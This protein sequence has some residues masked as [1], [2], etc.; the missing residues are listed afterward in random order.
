M[1]YCY[2]ISVRLAG[3]RHAASVHPEPGSNSPQKYHLFSEIKVFFG[4][5]ELNVWFV[6]PIT[7]Q[8]LR[9][10]FN[11]EGWILIALLPLVKGADRLKTDV[12]FNIGSLTDETCHKPHFETLLRPVQLSPI[13][14]R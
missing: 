10:L 5:L 13:C 7:I 12:F 4:L 6:L 9:C 2:N 1:K 8:L 11:C 3:I 14:F